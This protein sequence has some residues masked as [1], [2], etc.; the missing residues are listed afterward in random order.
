MSFC[1]NC[2]ENLTIYR[3]WRTITET[4]CRNKKRCDVPSHFLHDGL[5]LS[6]QKAIARA[7]NVY[8]ANIGTV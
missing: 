2:G 1:K 7:F 6:E 4:L 8:F 3:T 5:E